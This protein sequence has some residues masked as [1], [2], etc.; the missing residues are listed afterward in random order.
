VLARWGFQR[1]GNPLYEEHVDRRTYL[2][3]VGANLFGLKVLKPLP[4]TPTIEVKEYRTF[5]HGPWIDDAILSPDGRFLASVNCGSIFPSIPDQLRPC[6]SADGRTLATTATSGST[7]QLWEVCTQKA[8]RKLKGHTQMVGPLLF[9]ADGQIFASFEVVPGPTF[10]EAGRTHVIIWNTGQGQK[11][12]GLSW[13]NLSACTAAISRDGKTLALGGTRG[14]LLLV[15]L[16]SRTTRQIA[17]PQASAVWALQFLS[18][19]HSLVSTSEK[20][21][22]AVWD[23]KAGKV[24]L[25]WKAGEGPVYSLTLLSAKVAVASSGEKLDV[26]DV[27]TGRRI[28]SV[29]PQTTFKRYNWNVTSSADGRLLAASASN[30]TVK[31]WKV[32][33]RP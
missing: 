19:G 7:V 32:T 5:N 2:G 8:R 31:V 12:F 24:R 23:V 22:I 6:F 33:I 27:T 21:E 25:R 3:L 17:K 15:H 4:P 20:G 26:W 18:D 14:E 16:P 10:G 13:P 1:G 9:S 29:L 30:G 28:R 11:R